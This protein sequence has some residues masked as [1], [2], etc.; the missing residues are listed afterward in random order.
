MN[1]RRIIWG[2]IELIM[3]VIAIIFSLSLFVG[4]CGVMGLKMGGPI[5]A[6]IAGFSAI[7]WL[8]G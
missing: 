5:A 4:F 8:P 1:K 2:R 3:G 7:S 6:A